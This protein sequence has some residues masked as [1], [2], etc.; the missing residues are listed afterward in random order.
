M[1]YYI[2]TTGNDIS[3]NGTQSSPWKT[4]YKATSTVTS[5][6]NIIHVNAGTY[7]ETQ[8]SNLAVGVSLEGEGVT[9][10]IQCTVTTDWT[11]ILSLSSN[12]LATDGN[13]SISYLKFDGRNLS[14]FWAVNIYNRKNV[15][16]HHCS[17]IN[18]KDRGVIFGNGQGGDNA[19]NAPSVYATGNSFHDND[20]RNCAAY[21]TANGVYG[22]GCLNIGGQQ[23]ML[24][25]NNYISQT[26]R[27]QGYNGWPIKYW[28]GGFL[29]GC[30]I[31]NNVLDKIMNHSYNGNGA[32][33]F[34]IELFWVQGL[35]ISNNIMTGGGVDLNY[36]DKGNYAYSAWIHHNTVKMPVQAVQMQTGVTLEYQSES[37][38]VEDNI[39]DKVTIGVN[40]TPR[41]GSNITN[42][43]IRRNLM[44]NV[45]DMFIAFGDGGSNMSNTNLEISNNT[46]V[47]TNNNSGWWG[48]SLPHINS[49][50]CANIVVK[51]NI[52]IG[53]ASGGITQ[54]SPVGINGLQIINNDMF[55]N[56]NNNVPVFSNAPLPN[57]YTYANNLFVAAG[58]VSATDYHLAAN[59]PLKGKGSDGQDIGCY[60]GN[61]PPPPANVPPTVNAGTDKIITLPINNVTLNGSGTD[62]DGT[63]SSYLWEKLS[64]PVSG[65]IV[66]ASSAST[67]V[68]NLTQGVYVFKLTVTDNQGA[69]T[70]DT[71]QVTVNQA[72]VN[73]PPTANAGSDVVLTLPTNSTTLNGS[74]NDSD[75]TIVSYEWQNSNGG[76]VGTTSSVL[77]SNLIEGV[78]YFTLKVTDNSG[79]TATDIVQVT[80]QTPA[81]PVN[82][83][84]VVNAGDDETV[85]ISKMISGSATDDGNIVSYK[86][87]KVSGPTG[88]VIV[89]STSPTTQ[90]NNLK[91]GTYVLRLTVKDNGGLVSFDDKILTITY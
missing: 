32:W 60:V 4:L 42:N 22:R 63:I 18:F 79:A 38:I 2:S 73:V 39:F 40:Y 3:G 80:V 91:V 75:G 8:V 88:L 15:S 87:T 46:M 64:G 20:V 31:Y 74:G 66:S 19:N 70:S 61:T 86:W 90:L 37:V 49:G 72:V 58:F 65:T 44:T 21:N 29:N 67:V 71:A 78:H 54:Y 47:K 9:S 85:I 1:V 14:S 33:D 89:S 62:S 30:K 57:P 41:P 6:G 36:Q 10:V 27:P 35:E 81:P 77:V 84:P 24:I 11:A 25:Y 52:I 53:S 68:N 51:N 23:G 82:Q 5:P 17:V 12:N 43:I 59:S 45:A 50:T 56:G 83:P 28:N 7:L 16:M 13:Q 76:I 55:N 69:S 48:I 34:A 26:E